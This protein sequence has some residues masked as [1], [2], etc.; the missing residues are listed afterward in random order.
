MGPG[1]VKAIRAV[2]DD[3]TSTDVA[4]ILW[5][6]AQMRGATADPPTHRTET[7]GGVGRP[8]DSPV[9]P[10]PPH[11]AHRPTGPRTSR[12]ADDP[13]ERAAGEPEPV[14]PSA[15][16]RLPRPDRFTDEPG[17]PTRSPGVRAIPAELAICRALR[18][19]HV[20]VPSPTL[21]Q[22][23]ERM[24]AEWI[25]ETGLW[26]PSHVP[27]PVRWLDV[28]LVVDD[29]TS[30]NVWQRTVAELSAL[31]QR[32]GAFADVRVWHLDGDLRH[33][34][35]VTV[36]GG[37]RDN[38][39]RRDP[40]EVV[41][42]AGRRLTLVVS[43]CVGS[44]WAT[45]AVAPALE[46]WA[47][48][49]PTAIVQMLPQ[50]LWVDCAPELAPVRLYGSEP[51]VANDRLRVELRDGQIDLNDAG[52]PIPV[53][54][55]EARWLRPW[56]SMVAGGGWMRGVALFTRLTG[57]DSSHDGVDPHRS[58]Q[59][60]GPAE[61]LRRFRAHAS[62]EAYQLTVCLAAAPLSLP[63]MRLVQEAMSPA[64]K[65]SHL[66]EVF[67]SGLLRKVGPADSV[68]G[69]DDVQY[70]FQPGVR[71]E[72]LAESSRHEALQVLS[73]VSSLV[74]G[75]LG[76]PLDFMALLTA[77]EPS[78]QLDEVGR[79][80]ARVAIDVLRSLGGRYGEAAQRL[81]QAARVHL[82]SEGDGVRPP[83]STRYNS[84]SQVIDRGET[85]TST[86]STMPAERHTTWRGVLPDIM[87]GVP[88]RNPHF[89]GRKQLL[90]QLRKRLVDSTA[91]TALVPH[92]LH[93]L[94]GVGK[95]QLAVEY[96]Y[97]YAQEYDLVW[98]VSAEDLA[99]VRASLVDLALSLGI[100]E[101]P[102]ANRT[103]DGALDAL[104]IGH[105]YR[106]WLLVFDNADRPADL[107]PYLPYPTG[108]VL[109]T[110][111]NVAWSE[112][113]STVEVDVLER[114]ESIALLQE[115]APRLTSEDADRLAERLDNLPLALEQAAAWIAET[116][117]PVGEYLEL[118][119]T[120][121][122]RLTDA[123]PLGY[124]ATVGATFQLA[125]ERLRE[126]SLSAAQLLGICAFLGPVPISVSLLREGSRVIL[127]TPL[128]DTLRN[129]PVG[130]RGLVR[131]IG[132]YA[133]ARLNANSDEITVHR[134]VQLVVRA[135]LGAEERKE[136]QAAAQRI[137]THF[138][139]S[140]PDRRDNWARHAELSP[141]ILPSGLIDADD[142]E[143]RR[144]VLDQI[145]Y[146]WVRGD[147]QSSQELAQQAVEAWS[148]RWGRDEE[149]TLIACRHLATALR[150]LGDVRQARDLA[151]DT[152]RRMRDVFGDDH[153]HTINTAD[154][155]SWDLRISGDFAAALRIDEENLARCRQV[156]GPDDPFTLKVANNRAVDLRWLGD[157]TAARAAD[158]DSIRR[159]T[160]VY[161][162]E[163]HNTL[164]SVSSLARD[165]YGL[166]E[167][168][169]GLALQDRA[170]TLRRRILGE[171]HGQILLETR[172]LVILQR[173]SGD[174][175]EA[176]KRAKEL[177]DVYEQMFAPDH[178]HRLAA[179][180]SY[181]NALRAVGELVEARRIG[182]KTLERYREVFGAEHPMTLACV[183]NLAI[184]VRLLG[185]ADEALA[186][187]ESTLAT[188]EAVL[189][190]THP[191][192]LC[193]ATNL[194]S[195]LAAL[196]HAE[197]ALARSRETLARSTEIRGAEHPYTFACM[198]NNSFDLRACGDEAA[199]GPLLDAAIAGLKGK[200]GA[201]HPDVVAAT[202]G[203]RADCD[204]EPP[205]T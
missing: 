172:S 96:V 131:E 141:H 3:I 72:L 69:S 55:L 79:P 150:S 49:G 87:R 65:P 117:M 68:V 152:W 44:A 203:Q 66:A 77:D 36:S 16:L 88:P 199:A 188:F 116:G 138:S 73:T 148:Q 93:G 64:S 174:L 59:A 164:L 193:C 67:L 34:Q 175:E 25:A 159:R 6:S 81:T 35:A 162:S 204:I 134:L 70:D 196:G 114:S 192:T 115:R 205:E 184:T 63:V 39:V 4:D 107:E 27:V 32:T 57:V 12:P 1:L 201:H 14:H 181:H 31:L 10:S 24:T 89:T 128:D 71:T 38:V 50:R 54:Q 23:D 110:S 121:F 95:T 170:L 112:R 179:M 171:R 120:Q 20:R 86:S 101:H 180:M 111:R 186:L 8:D 82:P 43:D 62:P 42:P 109:V 127:P 40:R 169:E 103:V 200:L 177:C 56:A 28:A 102:E 92:A 145:R 165:L 132:R 99:Q 190:A 7:T 5:L 45:G 13:P 80:F 153:E 91:E 85:V 135:Q 105:P 84:G 195:D 78:P 185:E 118:F 100:L 149:L 197:E 194:A 146:L 18:P 122:E 160:A 198:L 191:F 2:D 156:L 74:S 161:G 9:A 15:A 183:S 182:E 19:F 113:A 90:T 125:L 29:S 136:T 129:N 30:M 126:R 155:V 144:V 166:G 11:D 133:L 76:S 157:F 140:E 51:G 154:S 123:P 33:G 106:R 46:T 139:P 158:E 151:E 143:A 48:S 124:P 83:R 176:R 119:E 52:L 167:Y 202:R 97:R 142:V 94:G 58:Q 53:L 168:T 187:N 17:I 178:E 130:L 108:H 37:V 189:G 75:R 21:S 61:K 104:R 41:D 22:P 98:W 163:D 47:R 147:Y 137:L 173:K 26:I 60:L